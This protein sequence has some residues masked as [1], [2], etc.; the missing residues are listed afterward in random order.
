MPHSKQRRDPTIHGNSRAKVAGAVVAA[1]L[2]WIFVVG[3]CHTTGP[4]NRPI[5]EEQLHV[6]N[7]TLDALHEEV[8]AAR[9]SRL[10]EFA[11]FLMMLLLPLAAALWLLL[12]AERSMIGADET[13]R[14][15]LR[16]GLAEPVLRHYLEQQ[17][18]P[19][20]PAADHPVPSA[21]PPN[22]PRSRHRHRRRR[23]QGPERGKP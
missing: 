18:R 8:A 23:G 16:A 10:A 6:L 3:P 19:R 5:T 11:L 7:R 4:P 22:R 21:L 20:L 9:G 12:R 17:N 14:V 15:L 13:I 2:F 1:I